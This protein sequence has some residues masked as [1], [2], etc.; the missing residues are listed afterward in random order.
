MIPR[1]ATIG[2]F[3]IKGNGSIFLDISRQTLRSV[4]PDSAGYS[5]DVYPHNALLC[6]AEQKTLHKGY[7]MEG[8]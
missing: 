2:R 4:E 8:I 6:P 1:K 5:Y 7:N 3:K